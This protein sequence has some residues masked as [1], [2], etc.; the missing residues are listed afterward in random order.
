M[1]ITTKFLDAAKALLGPKG[2]REDT[3]SLEGAATPW[4]G[5]Y[6]GHTEFVARP[7]TPQS[8][9]ELVKLCDHH[10]V[11]ITPQGGNTGLVDGGIP[12]GEIV[13]QFNRM[14]GVRAIDIPNASLTVEAGVTLSAVQTMADDAGF[15][16]PLSLGSEGQATIGGLISTNA[17]GTAVLRYGMMRDLILGVEAV[18][19]DGQILHGLSGLRKNNTGYNLNHIL[20]GAEGSLGLITAAT[21]R[22][23]PKSQSQ[24]VWFS[25]ANMGDVVRV[26]GDMRA[27]LGDLITA[28]EVVGPNALALARQDQTT[29]VDPLAGGHDSAT[30]RVLTEVSAP[31]NIDT[32]PA[33]EAFLAGAFEADLVQDAVIAK[34]AGEA[35]NFWAIR[36]GISLAKRRLCRSVNHDISVPISAIPDFTTACQSDLNKRFADIFIVVFGHV[37]DGNL[38]YS[39]CQHNS[40]AGDMITPNSPDITTCIYKHVL[41]FGGSVSA[42]HGVGRLKRDLLWEIRDPTASEA[43]KAIKTALDPKG[44][45]NPGRVI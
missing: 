40:D 8:L 11:C 35:Q 13:V 6:K 24:T 26:F 37:G 23:F 33:L 29:L 12:Y 17:G 32:T 31:E 10:G 20:A 15:Y 1:A 36:E 7:E 30:F 16:F 44:L 38:H 14:Q 22:L 5:G 3:E 41:A 2:W 4:R 28:Y 21:L 9:A 25:C 18:M 34:N 45:F 19:A 42:E 39:V 27:A 43:M